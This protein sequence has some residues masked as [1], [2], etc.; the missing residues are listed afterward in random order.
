[1]SKY[2]KGKFLVSKI[3]VTIILLGLLILNQYG[4]ITNTFNAI[5][6]I[7]AL[8]VFFITD[9]NLRKKELHS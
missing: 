3:V 5:I 6:T 1:M 8:I 2:F 7:V 4:L 9:S